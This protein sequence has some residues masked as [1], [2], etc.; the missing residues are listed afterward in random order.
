M[1]TAVRLLSV[2][3]LLVLAGFGAF[4]N[5]A[6]EAAPEKA[7]A[8]ESTASKIP[9]GTALQLLRVKELELR[10]ILSVA[11]KPNTPAHEEKKKKIK[12]MIDELFDFNELGR[13][14]LGRHWK[15]RTPEE[16]Q[17]FLIT[18]RAL[19]EKKTT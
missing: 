2:L 14:S 15:P 18:L 3:L 9:E 8:T 12:K 4:A 11:T 1:K 6:E 19:V 17:D 10:K 7:A 13:R 5:A 16:R